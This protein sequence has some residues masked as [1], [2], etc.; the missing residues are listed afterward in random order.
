[1]LETFLF[2]RCRQS[3]ATRSNSLELFSINFHR[4][5]SWNLGLRGQIFFSENYKYIQT[6]A[7]IWIFSCPRKFI[8]AICSCGM[9]GLILPLK[10]IF[11]GQEMAIKLVLVENSMTKILHL[12]RSLGKFLKQAIW[13]YHNINISIPVEI[14]KTIFPHAHIEPK[15]RDNLKPNLQCQCCPKFICRHA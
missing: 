9:R 1:M 6:E 11:L 13:F 5:D 10:R 12:F 14:I 4:I 7:G 3:L 8:K 2:R 15:M